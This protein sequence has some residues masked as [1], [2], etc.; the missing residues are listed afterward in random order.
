MASQNTDRLRNTDRL[1]SACWVFLGLFGVFVACLAV[2][3]IL[4]TVFGFDPTQ[5]F[6]P[7]TPGYVAILFSWVVMASSGW[8]IFATP[9]MRLYGRVV[10]FVLIV[11]SAGILVLAYATVYMASG[12]V[13]TTN[14]KE[15]VH[16]SA[17][18]IYFSIVTFTRLGYGDFVPVPD[19]RLIAAS[20]GVA[21]EVVM[22]L[23]IALLSKL[24][25]DAF[26][27]FKG[28]ST[29]PAAGTIVPDPPNVRC[30]QNG[31]CLLTA[32]ILNR[33]PAPSSK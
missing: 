20:E 4:L 27:E 2:G 21:G 18:C 6:T 33:H 32:R 24:V 12:L 9:R 25:R 8:W 10:A 5:F 28:E 7:K 23:V 1:P 29:L 22:V 30:M 11:A 31:R 26:V 13:D 14:G 15:T 17:T 16:A 19:A 3:F